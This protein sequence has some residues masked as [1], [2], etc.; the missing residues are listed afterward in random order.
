MELGVNLKYIKSYL[1][2]KKSKGLGEAFS[3]GTQEAK[4]GRPEFQQI[5]Q[6]ITVSKQKENQKSSWPTWAVSWVPGQL[7]VN[8]KT[9]SQKQQKAKW[10]SSAKLLMVFTNIYNFIIV[11]KENVYI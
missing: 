4:A 1:L 9:L 2:K 7:S 6:R 11:V 8:G 3:P 5:T 10:I